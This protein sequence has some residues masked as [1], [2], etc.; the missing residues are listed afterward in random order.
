MFSNKK[1]LEYWDSIPNDESGVSVTYFDLMRK[2]NCS[3]RSVRQILAELSALDTDDDY[4]LIRSSGG[5]GFYKTA[6]LAKIQAYKHE[7]YNRAIH[8]LRPLK[9]IRR[10]LGEFNQMSF[11]DLFI[12]ELGGGSDE[13]R[14]TVE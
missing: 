4:I 5:R 9:K 2:W 7:V 14:Q 3:K 8:T 12:D 6:D 13:Q 11:D 1:L 10:V